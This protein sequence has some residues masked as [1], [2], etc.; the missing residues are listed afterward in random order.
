[1]SNS[2]ITHDLFVQSVLSDEDLGYPSKVAFVPAE[3]EWADEVIWRNITEGTPTVI[4][5]N[6]F[7]VLVQPDPPDRLAAYWGRLRGRRR[8]VLKFRPCDADRNGRG[9]GTRTSVGHHP[10]RELRELALV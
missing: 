3:K 5:A 10:L 1:M 9:L 7:E 2:N 6:G 8:V 4:V